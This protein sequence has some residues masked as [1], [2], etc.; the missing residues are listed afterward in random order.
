MQNHPL[1]TSHPLRE[2]EDVHALEAQLER[3]LVP[4]TPSTEFRARLRDN[5][6]MAA[7]HREMHQ[8]LVRERAEMPW[9]WFV[10]AAALGSAAG[11]LTIFLRM[12][13]TRLGA[14]GIVAENK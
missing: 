13:H 5:L 1:S 2:I 11:L 14:L 12:R 7:Y 10:G 8:L 6:R 4:V 9:G 3:A